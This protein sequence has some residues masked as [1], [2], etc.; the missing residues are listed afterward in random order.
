MKNRRNFL[1]TALITGAGVAL[2]KA[3]HALAMW[4]QHPSLPGGIIYTS[5]NPGKWA[6][7]VAG[8]SPEVTV[9]KD[10]VTITT[11]HSMSPKHYIVRH[12]LVTMDG[13]VIGEKTFYPEDKKAISTFKVPEGHSMLYATS[14]CNKH[15]FWMTTFKL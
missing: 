2:F 15:D 11:K 6:K 5:E 14:F 7:K 10:K 13:A 1:K 9:D 4:Q 8:H 12:T 3:D